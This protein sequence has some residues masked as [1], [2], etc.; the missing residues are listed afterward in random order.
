MHDH[1]KKILV[2]D[3]E[4]PIAELIAE[5]CELF[6]YETKV[7][8]SGKNILDTVKSYNPDLI[9]LDLLMPEVPGTAVLAVL[10]KDRQ[11]KE[12]PV[13]VISSTIGSGV[14]GPVIEASEL[15]DN[16][17]PKP[18]SSNI[19]KQKIQDLLEQTRP[20]N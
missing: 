9:T 20:F 8:N 10:K 14:E 6:G 16:L 15:S 3:D 13:I 19:L 4:R 11:A 12:I 5:F 18:I 17:L 1:K 2:V 7:L